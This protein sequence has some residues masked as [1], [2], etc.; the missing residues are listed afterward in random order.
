MKRVKSRSW[1]K[2]FFIL[3]MSSLIVQGC[4]KRKVKDRENSIPSINWIYDIDS[5]LSLGKKKIG[6]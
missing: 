1:L 4:E 5:A 3:L 6:Y 2:Y